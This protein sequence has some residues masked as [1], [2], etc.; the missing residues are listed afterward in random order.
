MGPRV[1]PSLY[2]NQGWVSP[3]GPQRSYRTL[4]QLS[5]VFYVVV[6]LYL[7]F[8]LTVLFRLS[9]A[10]CLVFYE[11]LAQQSGACSNSMKFFH[12]E[13]A[14]GPPFF[15]QETPAE[16]FSVPGAPNGKEALASEV[17]W[18]ES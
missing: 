16:L 10:A 15:T 14:L 17:G 8:P 3:H 9:G 12:E 2:K 7:L 18:P 4:A 11:L 1:F 13:I 6:L 5:L